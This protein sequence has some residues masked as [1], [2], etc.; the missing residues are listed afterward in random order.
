MFPSACAQ[1]GISWVEGSD[2]LWAAVVVDLR[3]RQGL[4]SAGGCRRISLAPVAMGHRGHSSRRR[5][6]ISRSRAFCARCVMCT[7]HELSQ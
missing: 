7:R 4:S 2:P 1:F 6:T 5:Q 3:I